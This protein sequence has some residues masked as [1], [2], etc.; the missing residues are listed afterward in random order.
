MVSGSLTDHRYGFK[1]PHERAM[2]IVCPTC[3]MSYEIG[4]AALGEAGRS[5]RCSQCKNTWFATPQSV[6]AETEPASMPAVIPPARRA[7]DFPDGLASDFSV[8]TMMPAEAN[9]APEEA[10]TAIATI[11]APPL[12]PHEQPDDAAPSV[13][14]FE[15]GEPDRYR[16]HRGAPC[17]PHLR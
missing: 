3:A 10:G 13:S 12:A 6:V 2:L 7:D 14:K 15:P 4:L 16:D 11:E 1:H 5:V 8:Q 17:P 9:A